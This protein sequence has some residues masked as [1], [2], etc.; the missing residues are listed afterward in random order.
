MSTRRR[1]SAESR[2]SPQL[3][4]ASGGG[5]HAYWRLD[6][7]L[8]AAEVESL[9][10]RLAHRL[11]GDMSCTDRGRIMRMPG[12]FNQKRSAWCRIVAVDFARPPLDP[13][14]MRRAL[15]DPEPRRERTRPPHVRL[16]GDDELGRIP[17]P[18]YFRLLCGL[19]VPSR[20]G[21]VLCP[22]HEERTPSCMVWP[23]PER[24]W[25]CFGCGRG[26]GIYDLASLLNAGPWG[27]GARGLRA[28]SSPSRDLDCA[29]RLPRYQLTE[30]TLVVLPARACRLFVRTP[31]LVVRHE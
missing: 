21:Y 6:R 22:L 3:V 16:S 18:V 13:D 20:G 25:W 4:V 23:E 24:G 12:S 5:V 7:E 14:Q 28:S 19:A 29:A 8:P 26:G 31:V 9:N 1:G 11:G 30:R 10:R 27:A 2:L 15:P 17:P